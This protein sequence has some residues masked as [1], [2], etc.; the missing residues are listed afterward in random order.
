MWCH[1]IY[2][3]ILIGFDIMLFK[4]EGCFCGHP[5]QSGGVPMV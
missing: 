4:I 1:H 3:Y 2:K 5:L